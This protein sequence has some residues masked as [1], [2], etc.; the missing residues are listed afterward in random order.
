MRIP[1]DQVYWSNFGIIDVELDQQIRDILEEPLNPEELKE[2]DDEYDYE[3]DS[4]IK[5]KKLYRSCMDVD[6]LEERGL[7]PLKEM[8]SDLGGW[9]VVKGDDWEEQ[10]FNW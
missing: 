8:L 10:D 7:R 2:D 1:D 9:P 5:A 4:F 3:E 6:R